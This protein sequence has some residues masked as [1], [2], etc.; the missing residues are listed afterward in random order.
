LDVLAG[1]LIGAKK[2][3]GVAALLRMHC[4]NVFAASVAGQ[5]AQHATCIFYDKGAG[6][7]VRGDI[8]VIII[9]TIAVRSRFVPGQ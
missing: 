4:K 8:I 3:A 7:L 1:G 2:S 5:H 9:T 6:S